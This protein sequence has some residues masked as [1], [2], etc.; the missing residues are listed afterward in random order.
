MFVAEPCN[1]PW[2]EYEVNVIEY[3]RDQCLSW[4]DDADCT[5]ILLAHGPSAGKTSASE[6]RPTT[7]PIF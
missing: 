1:R 2:K 4:G 6:S 7:V 5:A 3:A